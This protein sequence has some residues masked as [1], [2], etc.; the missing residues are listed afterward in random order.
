MSNTHLETLREEFYENA[1]LEYTITVYDSDGM[2]LG[3][4]HGSDYEELCEGSLAEFS[5]QV[6]YELTA[7]VNGEEVPAK[8]TGFTEVSCLEKFNQ[9][10][11]A[12]DDYTEELF[13]DSI[14]VDYDSAVKERVF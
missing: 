1:E 7:T 4:K 11:N 5:G 8:R 3:Y 9:I 2:E 10:E 6:M 14:S 13:E 12:V